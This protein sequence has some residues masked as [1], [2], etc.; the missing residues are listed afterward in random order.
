[1]EPLTGGSDNT[2]SDPV[3]FIGQAQLIG[4]LCLPLYAVNSVSVL[5]LAYTV[6]PI[7]EEVIWLT[8]KAKESKICC[9][10][11]VNLVNS[12]STHKVQPTLRS[13]AHTLHQFVVF[14]FLLFSSGAGFSSHISTVMLSLPNFQFSSSV[15]V[16]LN[17]EKFQQEFSAVR[18]RE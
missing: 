6:V 4:P 18:M 11:S 9:Q 17:L 7:F 10:S 15:G 3:Y 8:W 13:A 2:H 5:C 14:L 1:M 16:I 12:V